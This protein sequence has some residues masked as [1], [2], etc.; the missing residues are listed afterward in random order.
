[1]KRIDFLLT[2]PNLN[3]IQEN[4]Q[5]LGRVTR[6]ARGRIRSPKGHSERK[7]DKS[8]S[9]HDLLCAAARRKHRKRSPEPSGDDRKP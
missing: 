2:N 9:H 5:K 1:M 8:A 4:C 6:F 3:D 7:R